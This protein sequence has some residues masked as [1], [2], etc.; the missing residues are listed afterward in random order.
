MIYRE[1]LVM[2]KALAWFV[3]LLLALMLI[4]IANGMI[5]IT[6][7][8]DGLRGVGDAAGWLAAIFAAVFGV[9]LGNGSREAARVLWVLPVERWKLAL[10]LIAV[11][12]AGTTL[13]FASAYA[14]V[15]LAVA[16]AGQHFTSELLQTV[17]IG[18]II[19]ALAMAYAAYGWSALVGMLGRRI[20]YCGMVVLPGLMIWTFLA[21]SWVNAGTILRVTLLA[22]PF[23]VFNTGLDPVSSPLQWLGTSWETPVLVAIAFATCGFAVLLWQ[24]AQAIQ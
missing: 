1:Y 9:A 4:G 12:L 2:R 19:M 8:G 20:A 10:Q 15:L 5:R 16:L 24:R 22:N 7:G 21:H 18:R 3:G 23:L 6:A 13:A 17:S 11:D 14:I